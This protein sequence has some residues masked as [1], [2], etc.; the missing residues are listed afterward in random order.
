METIEELTLSVD[1]PVIEAP[2]GRRCGPSM[3]PAETADALGR[4]DHRLELSEVGGCAAE[5]T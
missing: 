3:T 4:R 5:E 2:F 1:E